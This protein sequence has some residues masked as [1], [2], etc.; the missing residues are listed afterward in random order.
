MIQEVKDPELYVAAYK[1]VD[2]KNVAVPVCNS[3]GIMLILILHMH[4]FIRTVLTHSST[5]V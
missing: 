3:E 5:G 1:E 2:T 4:F